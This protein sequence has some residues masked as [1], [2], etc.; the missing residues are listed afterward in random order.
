MKDK[1]LGNEPAEQALHD[2]LLQMQLY[3]F[4]VQD[5]WVLKDDGADRR[6]PAPFPEFLVPRPRCAQRIHGVRPGGVGALTLI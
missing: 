2:A 4:I 5:A 6:G 1:S 3:H